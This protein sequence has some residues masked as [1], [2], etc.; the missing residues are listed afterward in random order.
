MR[1]CKGCL[2]FVDDY[3][4]WCLKH[5]DGLH[6]YG[7]DDHWPKDGAKCETCRFHDENWTCHLSRHVHI[8]TKGL[9]FSVEARAIRTNDGWFC[10][11]WRAKE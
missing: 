9:T 6:L 10:E 8:K 11:N 2:H 4:P 5:R 1:E 3:A 7:C